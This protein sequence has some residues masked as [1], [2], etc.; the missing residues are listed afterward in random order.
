MV[1]IPSIYEIC[2]LLDCKSGM[3]DKVKPLLKLVLLVWP[4]KSIKDFVLMEILEKK[5]TVSDSIDLIEEGIKAICGVFNLQASDPMY[6]F[7]NVQLAHTLLVYSAYFDILKKANEPLWEK[8]KL[9]G[10]ESFALTKAALD[11]KNVM[12]DN[13]QGILP[14]VG[15]DE[16]KNFY[17]RLN[18]KFHHFVDGLEGGIALRADW[19]DYPA[20]AVKHYNYQYHGLQIV[21][22]DFER[23]SNAISHK[24]SH[25]Q[26]RKIQED[27][28]KQRQLEEEQQKKNQ[29]TEQ[30]K[31]LNLPLGEV[32][33]THRFL[34]REDMLEN[35]WELVK[36]EKTI[37]LSGLGGI[38]KTELAKFFGLQYQETTGHN[39]YFVTFS[40]SFVHTVVR[41]I[42]V[43]VPN[44]PKGLQEQAIYDIVMKRL[45][46][47]GK[48]DL[49]IIDNADRD[50]GCFEDLKDNAYK[51]LI[52]L[53]MRLMITTRFSDPDFL[54]IRRLR[55]EALYELF[56][57]HN[58]EMEP[59]RMDDLITAVNGHTMTI[60]LFARAYR[61]SGETL[62]PE[63]LLNA[64]KNSNWDNVPWRVKTEHDK[65]QQRIYE[66]LRTLFNLSGMSEDAHS[67]LR[68]A[69]LFPQEGLT[70]RVFLNALGAERGENVADLVDRGWIRLE[71][72]V[73]SIHPVIRMVCRQELQPTS[74]NC[75]VFLEKLWDQY[76]P[77]N[78][79]YTLL[80]QLAEVF[81]L[82]DDMQFNDKDNLRIFAHHAGQLWRKVGKAQKAYEYYQ[83]TAEHRKK[84]LPPNS[85]PLAEAYNGLGCACADLDNHWEALRYHKKVLKI[86]KANRDTESSDLATAYNAVGCSYGDVGNHW[87]AQEYKEQAIKVVSSMPLPDKAQLA[88]YYNNLG[89][90][91]GQQAMELDIHGRLD[92]AT[93]KRKEAREYIEE[94]LRI[95][96]EILAPNNPYLASSYNN[97]GLT[98]AFLKDYEQA[99]IYHYEALRIQKIV[100]PY[101]HEHRDV[102]Y[103]YANI[104]YSHGKLGD[105]KKRLFFQEEAMKILKKVLDPDNPVLAISYCNVGK[106]HSYLGEDDAALEYQHMALKIREKVFAPG[107]KD[108]LAS[109]EELASIYRKLK[110]DDKA[111][112]YDQKA[113]AEKTMMEERHNTQTS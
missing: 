91:L 83:K 68:Y 77:Q 11:G 102:A 55:N 40:D 15:D 81:S 6:R 12:D 71:N 75:N 42:S 35:L 31:R 112:E 74:E 54:E 24:H 108:R 79:N 110:N 99:L 50:D 105:D 66:H 62:T 107:H 106:A 72:H 22:S 70:P 78:Y 10:E 19:D 96:K 33:K 89:H 93:A 18:N 27:S 5:L 69:T 13:G 45:G 98:H 21:S 101:P 25:E 16:L 28:K 23:W 92:E 88:T 111:K 104:G 38:G 95:R 32:M 52:N 39:V 76:A 103:S 51:G 60:D 14:G 41:S 94:A 84:M 49:L 9:T 97:A 3:W 1:K 17:T 63:V 57:I 87:E 36:K 48:D 82:A 43:G 29:F 4:E 56:R 85:L 26:L 86:Y 61:R 2:G 37:V 67:I 47:C 7:Q 53:P 113:R 73:Y 46:Q 64:I 44:L 59:D 65:K 80:C 100:Y 90:T 8:V 30:Q 34:G 109:Y 20:M 58:A